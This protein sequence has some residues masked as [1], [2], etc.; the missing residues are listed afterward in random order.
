MAHPRSGDD[1]LVKRACQ[2]HQGQATT[3][4]NPMSIND[5]AQELVVET[6]SNWASCKSTRRSKLRRLGVSRSPSS[7]SLV[8]L[9][10]SVSLSALVK[11]SCRHKSRR[12]ARVAEFEVLGG[13]APTCREPLAEV[14][15]RSGFNCTQRYHASSRSWSDSSIWQREQCGPNKFF[16]KKALKFDGSHMP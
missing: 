1:W 14:C 8:Q 2:T 16:N 15:C 11:L 9:F 6:D 12:S 10:K 7:A 13:R 4:S 5:E 3:R